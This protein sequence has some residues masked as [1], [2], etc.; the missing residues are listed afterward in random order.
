MTSAA[1]PRGVPLSDRYEDLGRIA[2]GGMGDVRRVHDHIMQRTLA[3]K[4]LPWEMLDSPRDRARFLN[5]ARMTAALQHPGVIPVHDCGELP[6]GRVW[7]TMKEVRGRTLRQVLEDLHGP[8]NAA[9]QITA[10][11][12]PLDPRAP[13]APRAPSESAPP[14]QPNGPSAPALRRVVDLF[15]RACEAVAYAHSVGIVH[16]DLKPDNIMIGEFGEVLVLD[17]GLAKR[18]GDGHSDHPAPP[19]AEQP[20]AITSRD[21]QPRDGQLTMLAP[22][23]QDDAGDDYA[24]LTLPGEIMGTLAYMPPEQAR[25]E[26][27]RICAAT[28]VYALGAVLYELLAGRP[29]FTGSSAAI[30]AALL[31]GPPPPLEEVTSAP[32]SLELSAVCAR[33]LSREPHDRFPT[34]G[35][36]AAEI[37]SWL[38]G[39]HRRER[40]LT[41]VA[42]AQAETPRIAALRAR[43]ETLRAE[44]RTLLGQLR[45]Y[46]PSS[47]KA[48]GWRAE[49]EA[50]R[51][52]SEASVA[53]L[54]WLQTLRAALNEAPDLPE[55]HEVLADHY[56]LRLLAAEEARDAR[57]AAGYEALLRLHDR[58]RHASVLA[59]DG[60][61]TLLTDAA[62]AEV[63]AHRYVERDRILTP[64][65]AHALGRTPLRAASLPRGSYLLCIRAPGREE[66]RYPVL[67]GR[68][69]HWDG[70]RPGDTAPHPVHLPRTGDIE[71]DSV[72][73]PAG[74][75][76]SGGDPEAGESLPRRRL[77]VDALIVQRHP[78]TNAQYLDFL[79]DLLA[80]GAESEALAACPRAPMG[81]V[82]HGEDALAYER[83]ADGRFHLPAHASPAER[84]WP[85]AFVD[86]RSATRYARWM[87]ERTG[88]PWR[89]LGE[90]EWEKAARGVDGRC[91]P[92]GD[93]MEP[94]WAC[95]IGSH[96]GVAGR[97]PV[98][99]Y[100][101]DASPYGVRGV[102]GNVRDWCAN[103]W[104]HEGPVVEGGVVLP[105]VAALGDTDLRAVRGGAWMSPPPLC[106]LAGRFA[107]PPGDRYGGIGFRLARSLVGA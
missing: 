47:A 66:V 6:D 61:L 53:E 99:E 85:V 30:W 75:F 94:T 31:S 102:T 35:A 45:P 103:V 70:T 21:G 4:I 106:R 25:G 12:S 101:I 54:A 107:T 77:W 67:I 65:P 13:R 46:D 83:D 97:A 37:R 42:E 69:E 19:S 39:A 89:L 104:R 5:E 50:E 36:L 29:P 56:H 59:G 90:L 41:I 93:H 63:T 2:R 71:A 40:A 91:M 32:P 55:A 68:G 78:V 28:D 23:C 10:R 15:L 96:E 27:R 64:E 43:A 11:A 48:T 82:S 26:L 49:D 34:A 20:A 8:S 38:D 72:Y 3:M 73:V 7:F 22:M 58:G 87:A 57:A 100:P 79:N 60:A 88:K 17:W 51:L 14:P 16:R 81:R 74:W 9:L 18:V 33:A 1:R 92:W 24:Q 52:E 86:W 80:R 95:I 84:R 76:V 105:D 44:A 98:D 62:G